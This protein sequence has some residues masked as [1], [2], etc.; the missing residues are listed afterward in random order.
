M[1]LDSLDDEILEPDYKSGAKEFRMIGV[2]LIVIALLI[3]AYTFYSIQ[4]SII[5]MGKVTRVDSSYSGGDRTTSYIPTFSFID[6]TGNEH[7][8][9]TS[10]SVGKFNYAIGEMVEIYYDPDD[11]SSVQVTNFTELWRLPLFISGLGLFVFWL[12]Y[13]IKPATTSRSSLISIL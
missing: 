10:Y 3:A 4:G 2:G 5:V 13:K 7:I 1:K 12:S 8:A 6:E 11:F 9:S